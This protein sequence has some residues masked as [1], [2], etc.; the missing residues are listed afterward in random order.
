MTSLSLSQSGLI[1][2]ASPPSLLARL[3]Y[4]A[5]SYI[6]NFVYLLLFCIQHNFESVFLFIEL[7]GKSCLNRRNNWHVTK[8]LS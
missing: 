1:A 6:I 3:D 2:Y 5:F 8:V 4:S 7:M